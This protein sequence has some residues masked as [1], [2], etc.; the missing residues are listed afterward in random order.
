[1]KKEVLYPIIT[2]VVVGALAFYGGMQYQKSQ[3]FSFAGDRQ[4]NFMMGGVGAGQRNGGQNSQ[5]GQRGMMGQGFRPVIG[6]IIS[7]DDASITVKLEDGSSKIVLISDSVA[8]NKTDPGS[9][10]DLKV[11]TKVGV[12][13]QD[14]NGTVTAQ[15]IQLNPTVRNNA[16]SSPSASPK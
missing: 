11:G 6:E 2:A 16:N 4:G 15:S 7:A 3:R 1:M 12:F 13:G 9:K 14:N 8:I 10:T 5:N